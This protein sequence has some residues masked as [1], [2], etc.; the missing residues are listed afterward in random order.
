MGY[1]LATLIGKRNKK[2]SNF[3]K[4]I[5]LAMYRKNSSAFTLIELIIVV[6]I[7]AVLAAIAVPNFLEAQVRAKVSRE[8]ADL[9]VIGTALEAYSAD[10]NGYPPNDGFYNV[11]PIELTTPVAFLGS[12][13][14]VD[15]FNDKQWSPAFGQLERFYT[16]TK[17]VSLGDAMRDIQN[18][19]N[20]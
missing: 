6:A 20:P 15:P 16:Y 10:Y 9:Y 13:R 8:K 1:G 5:G 2:I 18:H 14:L 19:K 12:N 3:V 4:I 11:I 7:I 17:I